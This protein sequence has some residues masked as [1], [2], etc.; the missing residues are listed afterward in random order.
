MIDG[1]ENPVDP[2]AHLDSMLVHLSHVNYQLAELKSVKERIEELLLIEFDRAPVE[3]D[4]GVEYPHEGGIT[5]A[6]GR[7]KITITT[8]HIYALKKDEYEV[9]KGKLPAKMNPF[10]EVVKHEINKKILRDFMNYA[11]E[12]ELEVFNKITIKKL[13]K[14][15]VKLAANV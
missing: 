7:H 10:K 4:T 2:K 11:S 9:F 3:C 12:E 5:Y 6:H 1:F 13:S 8:D 14:A 15:S